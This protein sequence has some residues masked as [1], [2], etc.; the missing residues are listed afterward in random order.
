M[1]MV[2]TG[3]LVKR[4]VLHSDP[5]ERDVLVDF[6]IP[7][8]IEQ[9][10]SVSLLLVNDGQD[11]VTMGF[12]KII[13][14]LQH[15]SL[16]PLLCVGIHCGEDRKLEY[17]M[18]ASPDFRGRGSKAVLYQQF[19]FEELLPLVYDTFNPLEFSEKAFAGFSLGALSA[20]DLV[21][22]NPTV[23]SKAGV[24]S[25]SLWW[26]QKDKNSKDFHES[27]DRL[28]HKQIRNGAY[29]E[30]LQFYFQTG[31]LDENEDRNNNGVIDS[32]DDTIDLMRELLK[33][34]YLEGKDFKYVQ[35]PNGR[36]DVPTWSNAFPDF[37]IWGWGNGQHHT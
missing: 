29:R 14:Y 8:F 11:L 4:I 31:E 33:K 21:W 26:R 17:G 16:K 27:T 5:L 6:Y 28:M 36:H 18:V 15:H 20:M 9:Y 25:G 24:F 2:N 22:N 19:I 23:F 35:L 30:G 37:L 1:Q 12:D 3:T 7:P 34:G 13:S 10:D 32:I